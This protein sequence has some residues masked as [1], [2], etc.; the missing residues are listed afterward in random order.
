MLL[1]ALLALVQSGPLLDL[2]VGEADGVARVVLVCEAR[3]SAAPTDGG[4]GTYR[5]EGL[6][7]EL[8]V[9]TGGDL[10]RSLKITPDGT[11]SVLMLEIARKPRRVATSRCE[12][13]ALCLDLDL[14]DAPPPPP[15]PSLGTISRGTAALAARGAPE[16]DLRS[17]LEAASGERLGPDDCARA[18]AAMM[19]DPWALGAFRTHALCT[20]ARGQIGEADGYLAR[21][22]AYAPDE[23]T[24]ALRA[25]LRAR[26]GATGTP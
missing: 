6:S 3:C 15:P 18:E 16:A 19:A 13:G 2:R 7:D 25:L 12:P 14:T 26:A 9:E 20:A 8:S 11:A 22:E 24:G 1:A 5:I 21:L 10:V 23:E 17:A 4:P